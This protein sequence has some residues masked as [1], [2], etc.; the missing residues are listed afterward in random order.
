MLEKCRRH[1]KLKYWFGTGAFVGLYC[2]IVLG[3]VLI[4]SHG[5]LYMFSGKL[6]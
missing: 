3:M 1:Q 2:V 4:L 6:T 5:G